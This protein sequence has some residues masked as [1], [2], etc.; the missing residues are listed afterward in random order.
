MMCTKKRNT[1][2]RH[3]PEYRELGIASILASSSGHQVF[4]IAV[5]YNLQ[6][7]TFSHI[8]EYFVG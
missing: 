2:Q 5:M 1:K 7:R 8:L 4:N 6:H 3:G